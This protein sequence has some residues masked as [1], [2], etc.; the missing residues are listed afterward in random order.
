MRSTIVTA[1]SRSIAGLL[2]FA[3]SFAV[4]QLVSLRAEPTNSPEKPKPRVQEISPGV[5]ELEGIRFSKQKR[6]VDIPCKV[7]KRDGELEYLLVGPGGK[8]HESLLSTDIDA[9]MLHAVMLLLG[10]RN[11]LDPSQV[12][13]APERINA[14]YLANAPQLPGVRIRLELQWTT[15]D[16]PG[17]TRTA[18]AADWVMRSDLG[19]AMPPAAW[20]YTGSLFIEGTF[21]ARAEQSFV[22]LVTDPSALINNPGEGH[23]KDRVWRPN[24]GNVPAVGTDVRLH[25][26]LDEPASRVPASTP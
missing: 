1:R 17:Q 19:V 14:E 8:R 2:L 7:E 15:P 12:P 11:S 16:A 18:Q 13:R 6:W 10:I 24:A 4:T 22:A 9:T 21:M 20:L 26:A 3:L 5:F 23:D 25:I